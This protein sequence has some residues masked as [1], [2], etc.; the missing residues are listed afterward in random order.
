MALVTVQR[1]PSPSNTPETTSTVS[2]FFVFNFLVV[3]TANLSVNPNWPL[4]GPMKRGL[5]VGCR[6]EIFCNVWR[7]LDNESVLCRTE[8]SVECRT[9]NPECRCRPTLIQVC[10]SVSDGKNWLVSG[11]GNTP[12]MGPIFCSL[13]L[14]YWHRIS[15]SKCFNTYYFVRNKNHVRKLTSVI[16]IFGI[17]EFFRCE[18]GDRQTLPNLL[19]P[20]LQSI[21]K[22]SL[23]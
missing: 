6:L 11:V 2:H 13:P 15:V 21:M 5:S 19:S 17:E 7:R 10:M 14:E 9:S 12:F 16:Q 22:G 20:M 8:W 4:I 18:S 23:Y 3:W 1:S